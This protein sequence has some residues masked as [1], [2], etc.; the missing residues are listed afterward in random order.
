[1]VTAVEV[2]AGVLVGVLLTFTITALWVGFVGLVGERIGRCPRCRRLG[3]T[4]CG[5]FHP[6]G[7]PRSWLEQLSHLENVLHSWVHDV[8]LR[9]H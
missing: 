6:A 3:M 9:H 5:Q 8:H 2:L 1:M 7:C 4:T